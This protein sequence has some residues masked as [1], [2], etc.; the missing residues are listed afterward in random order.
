MESKRLSK[1]KL[2]AG[3]VIL[4]PVADDGFAIAKVLFV[5]KA[6]RQ[7]MIVG[8]ATDR[9]VDATW[10]PGALPAAF[11]LTLFTD[12]SP[13]ENPAKVAL[14][15]GPW[16]LVGHDPAPI[17]A[18]ATHR[19]VAGEVY[20]GD[21]PLRAATPAD[22]E[23]YRVQSIG[24]PLVAERQIQGVMGLP[25]TP[26]PTPQEIAR[27]K[28]EASAKKAATK[29]EPPKAA[30]GA[31]DEDRF[32]QMIE[33]AWASAPALAKK[34]PGVAREATEDDAEAVSEAL[35]EKVVPALAKA[36]G[37]LSR[38]ELIGFD[39]ILERKLHDL[40]RADVQAVTD[41]SDDGFLYARGYIV[42]AGRAYYEAV[43][44]DPKRAFCDMEEERITYLPD[45]V[46][47]ERFGERIPPSPEGI[48]RESCSNA[49]GWPKQ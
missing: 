6:F 25:K 11:P 43:R 27:A 10:K 45:E 46:F 29:K 30:P 47:E 9:T 7:M 17:P 2:R 3:D 42:G 35:S 49:A 23:R 32:W 19:I 15:T 40:D 48:S 21:Q 8:V 12:T 22:Q 38:E 31:M 5:S 18:E 4:V 26:L 41:G 24:G 36:L 33:Q 14:R 13:L 39:R 37:K 20:E 28:K 34:R 16:L 44:A 1:T